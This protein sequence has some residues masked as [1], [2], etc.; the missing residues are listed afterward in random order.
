[1]PSLYLN[2]VCSLMQNISY[3]VLKVVLENLH[4]VGDVILLVFTLISRLFP[5]AQI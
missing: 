2:S 1:M 5:P 4:D 3:V